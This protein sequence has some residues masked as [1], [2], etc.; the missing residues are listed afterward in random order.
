VAVAALAVL[1]LVFV[2]LVGRW[3]IHTRAPYAGT[4]SVA[5][6]YNLP[7]PKRGQRLCI[8]RLTLPARA[9]GLRLRTASAGSVPAHVSLRLDAG[10]VRQVAGATAPVGGLG[11]LNFSIKAP[12][13]DVPAAACITTDR[14]LVAV[15]G[16]PT[17][18]LDTGFGYLDGK[19]VGAPSVWFL[20]TPAPRLVSSLPTAARRASL[21]RAGFVG[22]WTYAVI[23]ALIVLAWWLGLRLLLRG[24]R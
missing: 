3:L 22:A 10:G 11:P 20:H 1:G 12:G 6:K 17:E 24:D 23:A 13:R 18:G 8:K 21:F 9:N 16:Q 19:P 4:N 2:L 5:P 14:T 7:A 15:S